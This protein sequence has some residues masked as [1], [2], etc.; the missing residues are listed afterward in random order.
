MSR[1]AM[2]LF[3]IAL[4][5]LLALTAVAA[6]EKRDLAFSLPVGAVGPTAKIWPGETA[7]QRPITAQEDFEA[8]Q[9]QVGSGRRAELSVAAVPLPDG[10]PRLAATRIAFPPGRSDVTVELGRTVPQEARFALCMRNV[11]QGVVALYGA[12]ARADDG[13]AVYQG[14][15]RENADLAL[16]F[17]RDES[18]SVLSQVPDIFQRAALFRPGL[19]GAW[20]FWVMLIAVALGVPALLAA[21][22]RRSVEP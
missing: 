15:R 3:G 19:V 4:A 8:V 2:A 6:G 13:S 21:A 22:L 16:V 9:L 18:R 10:G 11:G 7:C 17:L 5:G 1:A 20:T 14:G 12:R